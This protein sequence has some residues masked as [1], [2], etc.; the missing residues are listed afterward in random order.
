MKSIKSKL[1][2]AFSLIAIIP[3]IILGVL[4]YQFSSQSIGQIVTERVSLSTQSLQEWLGENS[5]RA[6]K[7]AQW[8]AASPAVI[9]AFEASNREAFEPFLA[10]FESLKATNGLAVFEF[11]DAKGNVIYRLHNP[12]KFGDDKSGS[13]FVKA[14]LSGESHSGIEFGTSGLAIRGIVPVKSNGKIIG[15]VQVGIND[16]I[17]EQL[18][19]SSQSEINIYH[20]NELAVSTSPLSEEEKTAEQALLLEAYKAFDQGDANYEI[21][22]KNNV[23]R[24]ITPLLDPVGTGRIGA[25]EVIIKSDVIGNFST[26]FLRL[27]IILL[28]IIGVISI[29]IAWILST[30]FAK[31]INKITYYLSSIASGELNNNMDEVQHISARKDEIG[32]LAQITKNMQESLKELI[33][34][35]NQNAQELEKSIVTIG[36]DVSHM[37]QEIKEISETTQQI[38]ANMQE[39]AASSEKMSTIATEIEDAS[40]SIA[41]KAEEGALEANQINNRAESLKRVAVESKESSVLLYRD[42]NKKLV[43]AI[44][45]SESVKEIEAFSEAILSIAE[46]TNLLALNASIEAARAGEAGKGFAVVAEE[47]RKLAEDSK[48]AVEAIQNMTL[49]VVDSVSQLNESSGTMLEFINNKVIKDYEMIVE[50][51]ESYSKDATT[52]NDMVSDFS[53]TSEELTV[54]IQSVTRT[55]SDIANAVNETADGSQ[56]ISD[57]SLGISDRSNGIVEQLNA[58]N[59]QSQQ[60]VEAISR[61]RI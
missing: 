23:V 44:A 8:Y 56:V 47:I 31:P 20:D 15:T 3:L 24:Y 58:I 17:M 34:D 51:G 36:A 11:G 45:K 12:A 54:S 19:A 14:A 53:A 27:L 59:R 55:I 18:K 13:A 37:N 5:E 50:T 40:A 41:T 48:K 21:H 1:I 30:G 25:I 26:N 29:L 57:K 10:E 7:I 60:L 38:S 35:V 2:I 33:I 49:K 46:Q 9:A 16:G 39:T 52:V 6:E 42:V 32:K 61:F 4:A 43:D 22:D 28:A